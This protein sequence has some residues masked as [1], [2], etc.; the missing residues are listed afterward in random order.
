MALQNPQ[1]RHYRP[2][3]LGVV[4]ID[5][6]DHYLGRYDSP[7][8]WEKYH[9]LIA[10]WLEHREQAP[11]SPSAAATEKPPELTITQMLNRYRKSAEELRQEWTANEVTGGHEICRPAG[12]KAVRRDAR[13]GVR[14]ARPQDRSDAH[15]GA[16]EPVARRGQQSR[17]PN[18]AAI[19]AVSGNGEPAAA[20]TSRQA[21]SVW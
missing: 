19:G 3:N 9:R 15:G 12:A 10:G 17:Q 7:E 11:T 4:R 13:Q 20:K 16:G 6:K 5:G 1:Y 14:A 2:K 18:Q 21:V 8:S